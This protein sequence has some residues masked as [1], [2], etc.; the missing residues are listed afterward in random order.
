[1]SSKPIILGINT[2][3]HETSACILRGAEVLAFAEQERLNRVK[4]AKEATVDN[5]DELPVEAILYC[6]DRAGVRWSEIDRIAVSFDPSLR[7]AP[8]DEPT[9]PGGWG[10]RRGRPRSGTTC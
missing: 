4:H 9:I 5:P 1:M 3:Y 6:L 2:V 7:D 10:T 8:S